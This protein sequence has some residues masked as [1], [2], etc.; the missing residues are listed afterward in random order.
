VFSPE[1]VTSASLSDGTLVVGL[2]LNWFRPLPLSCVEELVVRLDGVPLPSGVLVV[3]G[4]RFEVDRLVEQ[5][6]V[7]WRFGSDAAL[8]VPWP[9]IAATREVRVTI[10]SRIPL[11]VDPT[12]TAVR[13]ADTAVVAVAA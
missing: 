12:G 6:D 5:D 7:W 13:V 1:F 4:A 3:D 9:D 10:R 2:R 11:L 8:H